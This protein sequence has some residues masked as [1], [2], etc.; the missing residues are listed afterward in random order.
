[1]FSQQKD[2]HNSMDTRRGLGS[3][4]GCTATVGASGQMPLD[5]GGKT[6][7]DNHLMISTFLGQNTPSQ[8]L[9]Q[10]DGVHLGN[11]NPIPKIQ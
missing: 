1:M 11:Q 10:K 9:I 2:V 4:M 5:R 6:K 3:S 8:S 7:T